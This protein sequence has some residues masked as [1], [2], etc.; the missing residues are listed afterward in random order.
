MLPDLPP[1]AAVHPSPASSL[2]LLRGGG[3]L[4]VLV[5]R[6]TLTTRAFP[7]A[8]V[9]P[10]GRLEA[11]DRSWP[12]ARDAL[13]T[14]KYAAIRETFEETGLLVTTSGEPPAL[15][16]DLHSARAD[17]EAGAMRF[18]DWVARLTFVLGL[19]R[20]T[21][22]AHWVTPASAPYRFDTLFFLVEASEAEAGSPL[23]WAEFEQLGWAAPQA[24][25]DSA[26]T[27]LVTP[28]RHCLEV[29]AASA[30]PKQAIEAA[31]ARGLIDGFSVRAARRAD[32]ARD[33]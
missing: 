8:T 10:G 14:A 31:K 3:A 9:F 22:F 7:G 30:T 23:I 33:G 17:I 24:L 15:E 19:D 18:A 11:E 6:R 12:G 4:E 32:G 20:L 28:T 26:Q 13:S 2:I 29:L 27:R 16:G 21:P 5:G 1:S 25:L